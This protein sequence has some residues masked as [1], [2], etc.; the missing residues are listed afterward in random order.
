MRK[1]L[2]FFLL[3]LT[4]SVAYARKYPT[5]PDGTKMDAWFSDTMRTD[6]SK[7]GRQYDVTAYG[8]RNDSTILQTEAI[9]HV[10]DMASANGG[11]LI[12]LPRG[13]F[14]S[15][16]LFFKPGTSLYLAQGATLKGSD[17][18]ENFPIIETRIEGQTCKY[19]AALVNADH[20]DG[21]TICG[22]GRIDG[23]GYHYWKE[24][25]IRRQWN[26]QC[27]NKDAQRPRLVYISNS[28]NVTIQD[29]SLENSP[30]WTS[31]LYRCDHVKYLGC[32]IYAP[33]SG[34]KAPS[35]DA[36]DLD[37]CH[38][39]L[40]HGCTMNVNDDA[41][42]IKGGKGQWADKDSTDGP[43]YNI[44]IERCRYISVHSCLTLGSESVSDRNIVI[45]NCHSERATRLLW[46]KMRP[47]TPQNYEYVSVEGVTGYVA[48]GLVVKPWTQFYVKPDRV[49]MPK[50]RCANITLRGNKLRTKKF[51]DVAESDKYELSAFD[52]NDNDINE[53]SHE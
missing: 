49:D 41:V 40:I 45:R 46:L 15:G 18:I 42:A 21:F 11:G 5:W 32:N 4:A 36:I 53:T 3:V 23:S 33:T 7:L 2:L 25:W 52:Y 26:P 10:I 51:I 24:F 34:V 1:I 27:T 19:F 48:T 22:Q 13:T 8:V 37:V 29:V 35:S 30:F 47:D 12:V 16:S 44:M 50:S 20:V 6:I 17:R 39:V 14:L 9:Q 43:N 31:H 28:S 38:D